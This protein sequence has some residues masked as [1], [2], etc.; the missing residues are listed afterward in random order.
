MTWIT[1]YLISPG[2]H[3]CCRARWSSTSIPTTNSFVASPWKA[4]SSCLISTGYPVRIR[5]L[6]TFGHQYRY[7]NTHIT[8]SSVDRISMERSEL[9]F[10]INRISGYQV[11]TS[12]K[13][14][15]VLKQIYFG[16]PCG[17][18][19]GTEDTRPNRSGPMTLTFNPG[20]PFRSVLR[21]GGW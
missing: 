6:E 20:T 16:T 10:D 19:G 1:Y 17:H 7:S 14:K 12:I 2:W 5:Y 18:A 9:N 21:G 8:K 3:Y 13:P 15:H 4:V 11:Q